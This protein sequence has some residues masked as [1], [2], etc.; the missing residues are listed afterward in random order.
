M[1]EEYLDLALDEAA[2][3]LLGDFGVEAGQHLLLQLDDRHLRT[4]GLV[5][6]AELQ[7]DRARADDDDAGRNPIVQQ[8]FLAG[9][10][11]IADGHAGKEALARS[12]GDE[13][14]VGL[15]GGRREGWFS[16]DRRE[17]EAMRTRDGGARLEQVDVVF[18]QQKA[19]A[20]LQLVG[21]LARARDDALEI[22]ADFAG[23]DAVL[24]GGAANLF[25]H[26]GRIEQRLGRD[27]SPVEAYAAGAIA[28]DDRDFH[29]ELRGAN[30]RDVAAGSGAD[31]CEVVS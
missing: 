6:V 2:T 29:F 19:D 17:R 30:G 8:S 14:L 22:D 28:F 16:F 21:S 31:D 10:H 1:T 27:T 25:H 20:L 26:L 3:Q 18:F 13:K 5:E 12:C 24:F 23:L 15:D 11:A 7:S 9:H 4:E